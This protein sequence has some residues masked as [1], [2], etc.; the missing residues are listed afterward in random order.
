ML[1]RNYHTHTYRCQHATG[2]VIDYAKAAIDGGLT[3]LGMSDHAALPD[4]RWN[5]VRMSMPELDDYEEA[6]E[7]ARKECPDLTIL[8]GMECEYVEEF[9]SYLEDELLGVRGFDYLIGAGHYTPFEGG[10]L[11]SFEELNKAAHL[12]AYASFLG[13]N[14]SMEPLVKF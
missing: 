8:K 3:T 6:I 14:F 4:N 13:P 7:L 2:D 12:R 1:Q 9:H 5:N 10:W 11:N